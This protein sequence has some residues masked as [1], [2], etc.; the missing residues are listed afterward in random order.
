MRIYM[1]GNFGLKRETIYSK[2]VHSR[3]FSY[4]FLTEDK[5]AMD[6]ARLYFKKIT[7]R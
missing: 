4:L 3:L 1:A 5:G 7:K 2:I 6:C